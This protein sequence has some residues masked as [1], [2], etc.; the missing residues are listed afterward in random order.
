METSS[1]LFAICFSYST[2]P[3]PMP[4]GF[5]FLQMVAT[6]VQFDAKILFTDEDIVYGLRSIEHLSISVFFYFWRGRGNTILDT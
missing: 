6:N 2:S 3:G 4:S 1:Q 5:S